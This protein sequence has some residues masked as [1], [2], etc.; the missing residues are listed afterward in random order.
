ME[1]KKDKKPPSLPI[2]VSWDSKFRE[3]PDDRR[4]IIDASV[5]LMAEAAE[6]DD[7]KGPAPN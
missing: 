6:L 7:D 3:T 2:G 5:D 4:R 1:D